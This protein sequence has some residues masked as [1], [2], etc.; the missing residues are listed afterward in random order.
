MPPLNEYIIINASGSINVSFE[1]EVHAFPSYYLFWSFTDESQGSEVVVYD[2]R[3]R[4]NTSKYVVT[5][6]ESDTWRLTIINVQ[7][8]DAGTYKCIV[9]ADAGSVSSNALLTV[10]C[11]LLFY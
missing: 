8:E 9:F 5:P 11:K 10:H 6:I 3:N 2:S 4:L 1:C 7:V